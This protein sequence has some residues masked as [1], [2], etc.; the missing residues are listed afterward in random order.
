MA[1]AIPFAIQGG[2]ALASYF[3][4]KKNA[5]AQASAQQLTQQ[6]GAQTAAAAPPLLQQGK[7]LG[8]QG[9]GYLRQGAEQ[10]QGAGSYYSNILSNRRSANESLAPE[11]A[12]ALEYYRGAGNKVQ[13]TMQGG[14]R[15]YAQAELDRQK[16]GQLASYVPTARANAA[17]GMERVGSAS[18]QL[19]GTALAAG[20]A[21]SG[22][23]VNAAMGGGYLNNMAFNQGQVQ[24][25]NAADTG[26]TWGKLFS[27]ALSAYLN[28]G[29][30]SGGGLPG[31]GTVMNWADNSNNFGGG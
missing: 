17:Q 30:G 18:G 26:N 29:K 28:R 19:G 16:V 27:S 11:N 25:Q 14:Q 31:T 24:R 8:Q 22:Q 1:A 21:A 15:D 10:L 2:S 5:K 3:M 23:G 4:N 9:A 12:T 6:S 20:G 13:R 7:E